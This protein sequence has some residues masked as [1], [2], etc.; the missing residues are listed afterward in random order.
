MIEISENYIKIDTPKT[1]L[2]YQIKRAH[3]NPDWDTAHF[4]EWLEPIYYG[5]RIRNAKNY[6]MLSA[7][8]HTFNSSV[9]C[10]GNFDSR[11]PLISVENSDGSLVS[12][13]SFHS[14]VKRKNP[15]VY[16]D[17]PS[18]H[19]PAETAEIIYRDNRTGLCLI[20][21]ISVFTDTDIIVGRFRLV[22]EGK[23]KIRI[24]RLM[25]LQL[26]LYGDDYT[27]YSLDGE[28]GRER[29][30]TE[31][32]LGIGVAVTES[33]A[34]MSSHAHNPFFMLKRD[35]F[36][37]WYGFNLLWS[38][39]H[40]ESVE[41][42]P[43]S[44]TRILMGVN[45]FA[46][47][48]ELSSGEMFVTPQ[49]VCVYATGRDEITE[50]M[51]AFVNGHIVRGKYAHAERP[52]VLNN[53]EATYFDFTAP[54]I[55]ELA[56][57]G[58]E[59]G[60][61]LF[62]LDDGWFSTRAT[63]SSG[64]GDWWDNEEKTGGG[65]KSL[66]DAVRAEGL[67]FGIWVEPEMVNPDSEL[68]RTHPEYA[69]LVEG[70]PPMVHRRQYVLDLVNP[71]V[72]NYLL[73][74]ISEVIK[75]CSADYVKWDFNRKLTE[76]YSPLLKNQG[77]YAY[78]YVLGLY[79][80]IGRLTERFPEVLFESCAGG[81]GRYDL[82]LLCYMPQ[83][84]TSDDTDARMR[85]SIQEGTLIAYPQSTMVAHVSVCPNHLTK[86]VTPLESVFNVASVG[87]LG[88]E[89]DLTKAAEEELETM[90]RQIDWYKKQ[91]KLLQYGKYY[92]L[93]SV[94]DKNNFYGG[95]IIVSPDKREAV[96]M[97][98]QTEYP[99]FAFSKYR[100][101]GLDEN[102]VYRVEMRR[103]NNVE[104]EYAW[105]AGGDLLTYSNT[106]LGALEGEISRLNASN[107]IFSRIVYFKSIEQ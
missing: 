5:K 106:D 103:Q 24:L 85:L 28:W 86:N 101:K 25:S 37:D 78:R 39:N 31:R 64:L 12:D 43:F 21:E 61:E 99:M 29:M 100:F 75:R 4:S 14:A 15:T 58:A 54:K 17:L 20:N 95:W 30:L 94:F 47:S 89:Y 104:T 26:D 62:V 55:R 18:A 98:A 1:T 88:Y 23:G 59:I 69:M 71:A 40:K 9:S 72:R 33:L 36:S 11:E 38:G 96:A 79:D 66:S 57:R 77:E 82:G 105:E 56:R 53:W 102:L 92:V 41:I 70:R 3:N 34:G 2:L 76:F 65:L 16:S 7:K 51:H 84:W 91:R 60:V 8:T 49:A 87:V 68:F 6:E 73:H 93:D 52:V 48:A 97:I 46:F 22:N 35:R 107:S 80:L 44:V 10:M 19:T 13:F 27:M 63:A 74:S 42:S 81:G 32:K 83:I 90:K 50:E 67:K 45:D